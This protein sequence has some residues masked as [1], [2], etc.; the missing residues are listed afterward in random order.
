[1]HVGHELME[2]RAAFALD[3]AGLEKQVHQQR[4]AAADVAVDVKTAHQARFVALAEKP[5]E[6]GGFARQPVLGQRIFQP[7]EMTN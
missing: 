6:R 7:L 1:M 5:S 2:M 4:L 3:A